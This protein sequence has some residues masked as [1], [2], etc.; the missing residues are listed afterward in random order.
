MFK[1]GQ[2]V[3]TLSPIGADHDRP[4]FVF[5]EVT[6]YIYVYMR[7]QQAPRTERVTLYI[8]C[9]VSSENTPGITYICWCGYVRY[10]Y[11]E[12]TRDRQRAP[13]TY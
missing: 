10:M 4:V 1:T 7:D 2:E 9:A 12:I 8:V 13:S 5:R 11:F 3:F 6:S